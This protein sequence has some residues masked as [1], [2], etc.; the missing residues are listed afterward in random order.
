MV[1]LYVYT[2]EIPGRDIYPLNEI[3]VLALEY[4]EKCTYEV[5]PSGPF[6]A[7]FPTTRGLID[8]SL[9]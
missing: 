3:R 2:E 8:S 4:Q 6:T 9:L 1:P 7:Q 5:G